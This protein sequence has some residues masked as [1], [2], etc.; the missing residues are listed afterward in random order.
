MGTE[1]W[2]GEEYVREG[3]DYPA[4][5][6]SHEEAEEF[7]R[8]LSARPAEKAAG[9][10]YRLPTEAEWEYGCR[11]GN[12]QSTRYHFGD[13]EGELGEYAW[14]A[15][16]AW[17]IGE[18]YAHIVGQKRA[19]GYGLHDMHGNVR[20]WCSDWYSESYYATTTATTSD[21]TGP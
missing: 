3:D 11:G 7:C 10:V 8:R 5:Y 1:P 15:K 6:I 14:Y 13:G 17:D 18:K 16:N 12:K 9:R 19:N 4:T 20:E 2:K 21:P